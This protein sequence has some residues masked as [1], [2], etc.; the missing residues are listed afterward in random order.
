MPKASEWERK[1][2]YFTHHYAIHRVFATFKIGKKCHWYSHYMHNGE[3]LESLR[4]YLYTALL[5]ALPIWYRWYSSVTVTEVRIYHAWNQILKLAIFVLGSVLLTL[6]A[7]II[8]WTKWLPSRRRYVQMHFRE[9][10]FLHLIK[11]S[12][13]CVAK[14]PIYNEPALV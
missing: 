4:Y 5:Y 8:L 3:R 13:T 9:L 7:F 11:M 10:K 6:K 1:T 2:H 12:L 14:G